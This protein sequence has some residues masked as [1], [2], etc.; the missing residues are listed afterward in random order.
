MSRSNNTEIQ[1][2]S[3]KWIQWSGSKGILEVYNKETKANEELPMPFTFILLDELHTIKGFNEASEKGI[4]SN[5]VKDLKKQ[6]LNVRIG[7]ETIELGLYEN[8]KDVVK[9][10]GGKYSKSCYIAYFDEN[11][12]LKIG[13]IMMTGSSLAGGKYK[14]EKKN[15]V[16]IGGWM[17][18]VSKNK[19]EVYKKAVVVTLEERIC[20]KGA[21][22]YRVP[23]FALKEVSEQT[24]AK[25]ESLDKEL[26]EYLKAYFANQNVSVAEHQSESIVKTEVQEQQTAPQN[27][28]ENLGFPTPSRE[29]IVNRGSDNII[30]DDSMPF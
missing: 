6:P 20:V 13:N 11:K 28:Y 25:A 2:P 27:H 26:Q 5:E 15:E 22:K 4:Y 12:E 8:I 17:D 24:N 10:K 19:N 1:N 18:F 3:T 7:K 14:D 23:K 16:E 9:V 29:E 30:D 21:N